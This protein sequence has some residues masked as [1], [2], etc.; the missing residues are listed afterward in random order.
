MNSIRLRQR[1]YRGFTLVAMATKYPK[2]PGMW[3]M[4]ITLRNLHPKYEL[5]MTQEKSDID[6]SICLP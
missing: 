3:L 1:S 2:Q 6:V 5:S 4:P